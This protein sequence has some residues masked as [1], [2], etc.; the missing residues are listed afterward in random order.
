MGNKPHGSGPRGK[1]VSLEG[2]APG[3][4][5]DPRGKQCHGLGRE[6]E[7]L[8][9]VGRRASTY[10]PDGVD[11]KVKAVDQPSEPVGSW[12]KPF[13]PKSTRVGFFAQHL[14]HRSHAG[15]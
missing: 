10:N 8:P 15:G 11:E 4:Q 6:V 5:S 3:S 2:D 7:A 1:P 12:T 13:D 14:P 9:P